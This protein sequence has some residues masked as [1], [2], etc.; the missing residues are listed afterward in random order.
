MAFSAALRS[1]RKSQNVELRKAFTEAPI[2]GEE[3]D[4]RPEVRE[5]QA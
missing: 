2:S 1:A 4:S 5:S 3:R